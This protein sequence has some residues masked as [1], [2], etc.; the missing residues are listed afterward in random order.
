MLHRKKTT[1]KTERSR[2]IF[3]KKEKIIVQEKNIEE[4]LALIGINKLM[5]V[6]KEHCILNCQ[7]LCQ[8]RSKI[9]GTGSPWRKDA[10]KPSYP[11]ENHRK[12]SRKISGRN[13]ASMFQR[14]PVFS[15]RK[16]HVF[17]DLGGNQL[18]EMP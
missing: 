13:T 11:T 7:H 18:L 9:A 6:K 5:M 14:F 4:K 1:I 15:C 3:N 16:R 10:R 17:L 8:P 12:K 2:K